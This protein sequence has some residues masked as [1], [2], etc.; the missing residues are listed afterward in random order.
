[1]A[2]AKSPSAEAS[3]PLGDE[4]SLSPSPEAAKAAEDAELAAMLAE[5]EAAKAKAAE[6]EALSE[7]DYADHEAEKARRASANG[8]LPL[9]TAEP[10][11]TF[12]DADS[13]AEEPLQG[14]RVKVWPYGSIDW[15]SASYEA[16]LEFTV[17]TTKHSED[18]FLGLVAAGALIRLD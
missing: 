16:N 18:A 1:M 7:R 2:K 9:R 13:S 11:L 8:D 12:K 5:E 3:L 6:L 14:P 15:D 10:R 17:D 4:P